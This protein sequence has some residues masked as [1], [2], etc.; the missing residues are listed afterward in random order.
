M[1]LQINDCTL[2]LVRGNLVEQDVDA[3]VN[4]ANPQLAGGGGVDGAI[5]S[6]GGPSIMEETDRR[7]PHGCETG[8]AVITSAGNLLS[9]YVIHTVG[10]V[11]NGGLHGEAD[12]LRSAYQNS[13]ELA[14]EHH[15]ET[16]AFPAISTGVYGYPVDLAAQIS[17]MAVA[18]FLREHEAPQLVRFVLFDAGA[19]GAFSHALENLAK[20]VKNW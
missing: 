15:C 1:R 3:I 18:D 19:Y 16:L 8:E 10:P 12:L 14:V 6:A 7:Y 9:Q 4:A 5:H 17:L 13:L 2:Q 11:W 20:V